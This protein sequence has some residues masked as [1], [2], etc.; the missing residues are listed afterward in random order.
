MPYTPHKLH[1]RLIITYSPN[2]A[3]YQKTIRDRQIE[4][5]QKM[6]DSGSIKKERKKPNDPAR[7]IGKWR[8]LGKAKRL[9]Y[10]IILIRIKSQKKLYMTGFML[11]RQTFWMTM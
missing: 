2:I 5:A 1:Q 11:S 9:G 4:R 6:I 8:S 10:I 3:R 7:F